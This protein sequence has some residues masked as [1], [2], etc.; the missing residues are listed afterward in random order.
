MTNILSNA[1]VPIDVRKGK[2]F[3]GSVIYVAAE[4]AVS[5]LLR[6]IMSAPRKSFA[7][8]TAVHT[9]S[10]GIMGGAN[11]PL[12]KKHTGYGGPFTEGLMNG[13]MG[14][15][16]LYIAQYIYNTFFR[17]FH[18]SFWSMKDTLIMAAAKILTRPILDKL[19]SRAK[20]IQNGLDAQASLEA[21]QSEA[22]NLKRGAIGS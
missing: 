9:L 7:E 19:Y 17:G 10:L 6:T 16:A 11:A 2:V 20:F 18:L 22:S 4:V 13:A 15:P 1:I 3:Q 8:L 5:Q 14:I 21:H 12:K